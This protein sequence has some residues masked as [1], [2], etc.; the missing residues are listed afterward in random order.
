MPSSLFRPE[1]GTAEKYTWQTLQ[2]LPVLVITPSYL[3]NEVHHGVMNYFPYALCPET[4]EG[5]T[6]FSQGP[7][8]DFPPPTPWSYPPGHS[9]RRARRGVPCTQRLVPRGAPLADPGLRVHLIMAFVIP[10]PRLDAST[11]EHSPPWAF[12]IG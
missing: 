10:S 9:A 7:A 4:A 2:E 3:Q 1:K 8:F 12:E 5:N 6:A 11:P